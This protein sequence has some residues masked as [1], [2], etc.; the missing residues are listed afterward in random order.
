[1][2]NSIKN[3]G[4]R[5]EVFHGKAKQTGGGLKK[6]DLMLNK[7]GAIVSVKASNAAKKNDNLV[8][9]GYICKKGQFGSQ[10]GGGKGLKKSKSH[11]NKSNEKDN[12]KSNKKNSKNKKSNEN[13][14]VS[15]F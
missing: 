6:E 15:F 9:A 12:K 1:M 13:K 3:K 10:F 14:D 7:G 11:K 5:L 2:N 4:T 8:K